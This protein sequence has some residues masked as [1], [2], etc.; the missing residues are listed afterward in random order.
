[1]TSEINDNWNGMSLVDNRTLLEEVLECWP[2]LASMYTQKSTVEIPQ[3][4]I[5][6][7]SVLDL[8]SKYANPKLLKDDGKELAILVDC[9][10]VSL[11]IC[12]ADMINNGARHLENIAEYEDD[13]VNYHSTLDVDGVQVK[14]FYECELENLLVFSQQYIRSVMNMVSGI[15]NVRRYV[16]P[17]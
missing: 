14:L 10:P 8:V 3:T 11:G 15:D 6:Y 7:E 12:I 17:L 4:V 13:K 2:E 9:E 16:A 1:M 5:H